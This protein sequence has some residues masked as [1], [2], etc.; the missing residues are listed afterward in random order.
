MV[1]IQSKEAV[2]RM[3]EELKIQPALVL[4]KKLADNIQP[5]FEISKKVANIVRSNSNAV[6]GSLTVYT[7]PTD[8]DFFLT[9]A[10]VGHFE[11]NLSNNILTSLNVVINGATRQVLEIAKPG[12]FQVDQNIALTFDTPIKIDR[13][14]NITVSNSF[15]AGAATKFATLIGY[16]S[17]PI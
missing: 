12:G 7:T 3:S 4:P 9:A 6:T 13:G 15:G 16:T 2:D 11:N 1:D 5:V 14:T 17:D 8:Q 10:T